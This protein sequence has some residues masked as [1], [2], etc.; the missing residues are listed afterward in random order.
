MTQIVMNKA[1][2]IFGTFWKG[3]PIWN[4][5]TCFKLTP[6][7]CA[8]N[9]I[10]KISN[11]NWFKFDN[12]KLIGKKLKKRLLIWRNTKDCAKYKITEKSCLNEY[13]HDHSTLRLRLWVAINWSVCECL[14]IAW[15]P[16]VDKPFIFR[17]ASTPVATVCSIGGSILSFF[18]RFLSNDALRM[19]ANSHKRV[20]LNT[21]LA[22]NAPWPLHP[23][24]WVKCM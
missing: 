5:R 19:D 24:L 11:V 1:V 22:S 21:K 7:T 3:I 17:G 9:L 12:A 2:P 8:Q 6:Q 14:L 16:F 15:S 18:E 20:A 10:P 13:F 23:S 4:I